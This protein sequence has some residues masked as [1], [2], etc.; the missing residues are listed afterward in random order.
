ML[1]LIQAY[2]SGDFSGGT[3]DAVLSY[4][5]LIVL[6]TLVT[7]T[8][9][10]LSTWRSERQVN[11]TP[12]DDSPDA[13]QRKIEEAKR[14]LNP[15]DRFSLRHLVTWH[16]AALVVVTAMSA[17]SLWLG[18]QMV[19]LPLAAAT[20]L[21]YRWHSHLRRSGVRWAATYSM[22]SWIV[23]YLV[24]VA[25]TIMFRP[26]A[27]DIQFPSYWPRAFVYSRLN[28]LDPWLLTAVALYV[29]GVLTA[30]LVLALF[31]HPLVN[32]AS[33][34]AL[35]CPIALCIW[36]A[37]PFWWTLPL[38]AFTM[39]ILGH[40][41]SRERRL[42]LEALET[43]EGRGDH[44]FAS[45]WLGMLAVTK[46][47]DPIVVMLAIATVAIV[48]LEY[49]EIA[50]NWIW[51]RLSD[52]ELHWVWFDIVRTTLFWAPVIAVGAF[53]C[54]IMRKVAAPTQVASYVAMAMV[55]ALMSHTLFESEWNIR[56]LVRLGFTW[57]ADFET[58]EEVYIE[59]GYNSAVYI[60]PRL[61]FPGE[62]GMPLIL[63]YIIAVVLAIGIFW[64]SVRGTIANY[65]GVF[66]GMAWFIF[67]YGV[68]E[69]TVNSSLLGGR[70][71]GFW[72]YAQND[73][74]LANLT[75]A[76]FA[77]FA[78]LYW[79]FGPGSIRTNTRHPRV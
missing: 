19:V 27:L 56:Q 24:V 38:G 73:L 34:A 12:L 7:G 58:F 2:V 57:A 46:R 37:H 35:A 59:M 11:A 51:G 67:A 61:G 40:A 53:G 10:T 65:G 1:D 15:P 54:V 5:A 49:D 36:F 50:Y 47:F 66:G 62:A 22:T 6:G 69:L 48:A 33:I 30:S 26:S 14:I 77:M 63:S 64:Q 74:L 8:V 28:E 72:Q 23:P 45:R 17:A 31:R 79:G 42:R 39:V 44:R 16:T 41:M 43:V 4:M 78:L 76:A 60:G 32:P 20:A 18:W 68:L 52:F 70:S 21:S 75:I 55:I 29:L 3:Y 13:V 71:I 25:T 9:L